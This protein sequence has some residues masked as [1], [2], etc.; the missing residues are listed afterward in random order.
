MLNLEQHRTSIAWATVLAII[1]AYTT[2]AVC[3]FA[4][5]G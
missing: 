1:A 4:I 5:G 3:H 2:L